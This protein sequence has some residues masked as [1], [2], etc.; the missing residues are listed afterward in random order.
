MSSALLEANKW[1]SVLF[2]DPDPAMA[3]EFQAALHGS[4]FQ[5][6]GT[7]ATGRGALEAYER[8]RPDI[9]V[10]G[11]VFPD[12]GGAAVVKEII[13]G[14][15][16]AAIV[17]TY[18]IQAKHMAREA[19]IAGAVAVKKPFQRDKL[20]ERMAS[21]LLGGRGQHNRF[22]MRLEQPLVVHW[23][24]P[25]LLARRKTAVAANISQSGISLVTTE[26][27][28]ERQTL[29][30]EIEIPGQPPPVRVTTTVMKVRR[31]PD[32]KVT[33]AG[34]AFSQITEPDRLR[35]RKHILDSVVR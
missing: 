28:R 27:L 17:V 13:A 26:D 4:R 30:V 8:L 24:P 7:S 35:I 9:A 21:A 32:G 22:A 20:L 15:A 31:G 3:A 2:A 23:K 16:E 12:L 33:G 34:L 19:E 14:D 29:D 11:L 6:C 18:A 10:V 1:I 25:G 5:V